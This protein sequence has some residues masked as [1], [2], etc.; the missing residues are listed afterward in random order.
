MTEQTI[1]LIVAHRR[2]DAEG[3]CVFEL[4]HPEGR[5]LPSFTAGS[6]IEVH[7]PKMVR[8]YSL[9]NSPSDRSRY[10]IGVLDQPGGRGGSR[11]IHERLKIGDEIEVGRPRN[12]F[13]LNESAPASILIAGGIGVTPLL[14]MM[15][16]L[17]AIGAEYQFHYFAASDSKMAFKERF[18]RSDFVA[19]THLH[20]GYDIQAVECQ[21]DRV[22]GSALPDVHV[23][24]CGPQGLIDA[25]RCHAAKHGMSQAQVHFE[26]FGTPP[27]LQTEADRTFRIVIH[28]TGQSVEIPPGVP[29]TEALA[30]AGV[31]IPTSCEAGVCGTCRTRVVE[32]QPEHRDLYLT[33]EEQASNQVFLPCCSRSIS[34]VLV[35][36][37]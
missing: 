16:S 22:L 33:P 5:E 32:G 19:R 1:R 35:I 28:R 27:P 31:V 14:S 10:V 8:H 29:V 13:E 36:D 21:L 34:S 25:V 20:L 2:T 11:W 26:L 15:E 30:S 6:H 9:C 17:H 37:L 18:Q 4:V 3:V 23:Y 12:F 24:A 7:L